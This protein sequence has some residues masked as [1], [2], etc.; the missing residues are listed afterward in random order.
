MCFY[1]SEIRLLSILLS[2]RQLR[3]VTSLGSHNRL[4]AEMKKNHP[5]P[6]VSRPK[7]PF[8]SIV[9]WYYSLLAVILPI[10]L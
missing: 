4:V 8:S 3:E 7:L 9:L 6:L 1:M 5:G 2:S 10:F